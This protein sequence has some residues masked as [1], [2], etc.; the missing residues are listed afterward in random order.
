MT[1]SIG[2]YAALVSILAVA[3]TGAR[4]LIL[5]IQQGVAKI[6]DEQR[7]QDARLTSL[8]KDKV[9]RVDWAREVLRSSERL[10]R[11][12]EA[13]AKIDG[14][15]DANYGMTGAVNRLAEVMARK[16]GAPT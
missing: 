5:P 15:L 2:D 6:G 4:F 11:V 9:D 10:D 12:S 8:E 3:L 1:L 14:K 7:R 16:Q 13:I